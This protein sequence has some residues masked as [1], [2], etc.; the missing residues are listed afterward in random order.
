[1]SSANLSL[2][3]TANLATGTKNHTPPGLNFA[4]TPGNFDLVNIPSGN[5]T[6]TPPA[7]TN[8]IVVIMPPTAATVTIKGV[9]GDV[10]IP[11]A[12]SATDVR[13]FVLPISTAFVVNS[14]LAIN[15]IEVL[16]L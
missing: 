16:Y 14:T 4:A 7:G 12:L 10:G 6:V 1:M 13:W 3:I 5:V 8:S 2:N 9:T 15:G 11:L